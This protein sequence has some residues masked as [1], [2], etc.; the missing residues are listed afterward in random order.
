MFFTLFGRVD[1]ALAEA[2]K[3][4]A[5]D[6]F[7]GRGQEE[8]GI[9]LLNARRYDEAVLELRRAIE[10][11]PRRAGPRWWLAVAFAE[12]GRFEESIAEHQRALELLNRSPAFLGTLGNVYAGPGAA[13]GLSPSATSSWRCRGRTTSPRPRSCSCIPASGT[14]TKPSNGWTR[15]HRTRPT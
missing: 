15:R 3:A 8:I 6:P 12:Q 4:T 5:L 9:A 1:E 13:I 14:R 2:R 7:A 10:I 11:D